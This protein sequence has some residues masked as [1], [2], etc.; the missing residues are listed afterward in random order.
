MRPLPSRAGSTALSSWMANCDKVVRAKLHSIITAI[1]YW[2]EPF[3]LT[4]DRTVYWM[5]LWKTKKG[6]KKV[7][8]SFLFPFSLSKNRSGKNVSTSRVHLLN[9]RTFSGANR[10]LRNI[11]KLCGSRAVQWLMRSLADTPVYLNNGS[12]FCPLFLGNGKFLPDN[13]IF[14]LKDRKMILTDN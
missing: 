2:I 4:L 12:F 8:I 1:F 5:C 3:A 11:I 10:L 7:Y 9:G 6:S 14:S 13:K